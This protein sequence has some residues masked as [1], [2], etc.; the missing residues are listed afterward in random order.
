MARGLN[1]ESLVDLYVSG[2]SIPEVSNN[3]GIALSTVR[4]HLSI[5]GVL[6][7]RADGV[8]NAGA[9]GRLGSGMRGKKRVFTDSHCKAISTAKIL[10]ADKFSIGFRKKPSGYIEHTRGKNKG[11][12]SHRIIMEGHLG[13]EL[14]SSEHVHHKDG[15]KENNDIENLEIMTASQHSSHHAKENQHNRRRNQNGT[16][17]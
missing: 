4:R 13:R 8:R 2:L 6:R 15:N 16:W 3:T 12:L 7:S 1:K 9:N 11:K 5:C 10:Q 14:L 17:R